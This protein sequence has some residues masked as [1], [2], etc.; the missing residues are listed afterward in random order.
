MPEP[1]SL[2]LAAVAGAL[3]PPFPESWLP[4]VA[5]LFGA[6]IGS[7][8][9]VC[10]HRI[11]RELSIVRPGSHCPQ[12]Q[13]PIAWYDNIPLASWVLLRARCRR[14]GTH[15]SARYFVVELLTALLFFGIAWRHGF[16]VRTPVYCV[17]AS[18]LVLATFVDL[19]EMYIPDRVSLGGIALGLVLGPLAP[20]LHDA[21][22]AW[23][24]LKEAAIGAAAGSGLLGFVAL[25]GEKIFKKEAMGMGDVK[26]VGAIGALMGWPAV[27]FTFFFSSLF[28]AIAGLAMIAARRKGMAS[29]IP[30]GPYIALA[31]VLWMLG[32]S[33]LWM[34]YVST[35]HGARPGFGP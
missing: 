29:E 6:C 11:P 7:F 5:F 12:C 23:G 10:I 14:C 19:D 26:L 20:S 21:A 9:N 8:L 22:T 32:G 27:V 1:G 2:W 35:I 17:A 13:A 31:A 25:A 4:A 34:L 30:F 3:T 15:I 24:G 28:G 18:G 33:E 16:D